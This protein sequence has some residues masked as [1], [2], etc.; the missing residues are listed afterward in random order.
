M[1]DACGSASLCRRLAGRMAAEDC[2]LD[3]QRCYSE[4]SVLCKEGTACTAAPLQRAVYWPPCVP[5]SE[6]QAA[7]CVRQRPMQQIRARFSRQVWAGTEGQPLFL[8]P[9]LT[10][11][12]PLSW[13]CEGSRPARHKWLYCSD[14]GCAA[15]KHRP[16][17]A[18]VE[19]KPHPE[20]RWHK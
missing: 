16:C 10:E 20:K 18:S 5:G 12:L 15:Q 2:R 3:G 13:L 6:W 11:R 1:R 17:Q 4:Q 7:L 14:G 19:E 9:W 8:L